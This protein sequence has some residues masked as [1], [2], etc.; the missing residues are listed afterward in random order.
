MLDTE[1]TL[2][3]PE[4]SLMFFAKSG[5]GLVQ[6]RAI[7]VCTRPICTV[8]LFKTVLERE[9]AVLEVEVAVKELA[10]RQRM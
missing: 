1:L 4:Y 9:V 6:A 5:T 8:A 3:L 2:Q 10:A 7:R